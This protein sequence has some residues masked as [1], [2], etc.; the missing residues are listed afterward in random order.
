MDYKKKYLK[1][2]NK[3]FKLKY[4]GMEIEN[5]D[6]KS[7]NTDMEIENTGMEIENTGEEKKLIYLGWKFVTGE[8]TTNKF[9]FRSFWLIPNNNPKIV[10]IKGEPLDYVPVYVSSG[11]NTPLSF[12]PLP[13]FGFVSIYQNGI[14]IGYLMKSDTLQERLFNLP[15]IQQNYPKISDVKK[16]LL[17]NES[18]EDSSIIKYTEDC[19]KMFDLKIGVNSEDLKEI[20]KKLGSSHL[21]KLINIYKDQILKKH[22]EIKIE[23]EKK[24][25]QFLSSHP[26]FPIENKIKKAELIE[27]ISLGQMNNLIPNL[28]KLNEFI[29]DNKANIF[30]NYS[31]NKDYDKL[32]EGLVRILKILRDERIY[33]RRYNFYDYA[34][35]ILSQVY[36]AKLK[37]FLKAANLYEKKSIINKIII[38]LSTINK[39][40]LAQILTTIHFDGIINDLYYKRL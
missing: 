25:S 23:G 5:T 18:L 28:S 38:N 35:N 3:Y 40:K 33:R 27:F 13:F 10:N 8:R 12:L 20:K 29:N 11:S 19:Q 2:K 15:R 22:K 21:L 24:L 17:D 30:I 7:E 36:Q 32:F 16:I 31:R 14:I 34:Y 1:Y 6:R 37:P 4:G 39:Y 9:P 26:R